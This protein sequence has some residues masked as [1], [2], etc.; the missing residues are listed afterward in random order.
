V[1]K[2]HVTV[3]LPAY[4]EAATI[5]SLLGQI[6]MTLED[7]DIQYSVI[8]VDD[9]ST[10]HTAEVVNALANTHVEIVRHEVN[11]GLGGA[12]RTGLLRAVERAPERAV[13]VTMD[14]DSTHNPGL[15]VRMIRALNEGFDVVIA[16]R[17]TPGA[18]VVGVPLV[19]RLLST[20]ASILF[21]L[22][23]PIKGV[24]DY[25]S[26]YRAYQ[27]SVLAKAFADY[28]QSLI[29]AS[30]FS[31]MVELLLRLRSCG[32]L[33]T[34]MPIL[35]RYDQKG[36]FSKMRVGQNVRDLLRVLIRPPG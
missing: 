24:R 4:N 8:V 14:A 10:D 23:F 21:R 36:G 17:F 15:I 34:E 16:S 20:G 12:I 19:R 7:E 3:V 35:L 28:G 22:R 31:S 5:G 18:R 29:R 2:T 9:G 27:A 25:T 26:G 11:Q 13:I 1:K 30:G 32:V 33:M 6:F